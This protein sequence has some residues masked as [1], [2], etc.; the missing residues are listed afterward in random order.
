MLGHA[1]LLLA[2]T[3]EPH[4]FRSFNNGRDDDWAKIYTSA[5]FGEAVAERGSPGGILEER[6][7]QRCLLAPAAALLCCP[8]AISWQLLI[9]SRKLSLSALSGDAFRAVM[10]RV[11]SEG[12]HCCGCGFAGYSY[13][14]QLWMH[15]PGAP[16]PSFQACS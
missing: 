4:D 6:G 11:H 13:R 9:A 2:V 10:C 1:G 15:K 3:R 16:L 14:C 5:D 12:T 7:N 8:L